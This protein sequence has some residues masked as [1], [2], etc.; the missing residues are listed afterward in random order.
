M[1]KVIPLSTLL[2]LSACQKERQPTSSISHHSEID[3]SI[4]NSKNSALLKHNQ[5][6]LL[7][8]QDAPL[9]YSAKLEA[10]AQAYAN[11]LAQTG[12]FDHDPQNLEKKYGENLFA[13]SKATA[14]N[15]NH[16]IQKWYDEGQYYNYSSNRC[17][18]G[19]I[20]G[21]YTQIIWKNSK[22]LGCASAKYQKGRFKGGY[23]TVCKYYPY[24][25]IVGQTPY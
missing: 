5:L 3:N 24:G 21:H 18:S 17:Q 13:F 8:F 1:K 16:I 22:F 23:V 19:H 4:I 12:R 2:L 7:H 25:N 20:C 15:Y 6:R 10:D 9:K 11:K 14:P